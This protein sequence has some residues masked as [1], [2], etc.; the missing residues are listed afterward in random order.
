MSFALYFPS[1]SSRTVIIE[2]IKSTFSTTTAKLICLV[3]M[4]NPQ[5]EQNMVLDFKY[6][7]YR[8]SGKNRQEIHVLLFVKHYT[9]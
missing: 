3:Y 8:Q 2:R 7:H 6:W 5:L 1:R 4:L 9:T